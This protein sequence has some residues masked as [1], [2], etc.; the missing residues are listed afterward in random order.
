MHISVN[1]PESDTNGDGD[2]IP[3]W[4]VCVADDESG[5]PVGKVYW[6]Y[7]CACASELGRRMARDRRLELIDEAMPA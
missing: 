1:G 3:V 7:S 4:T 6:V 5:E 2:E